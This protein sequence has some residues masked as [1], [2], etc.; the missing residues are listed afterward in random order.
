MRNK[1]LFLIACAFFMQLTSVFSIPVISGVTYAPASV[2]NYDK[3]E[4]SF[5]L[6][7]YTNPFDPAVVDAYCEFWSPTNVY[8]RVNAFY[9]TSYTEDSAWASCDTVLF[10]FSR[11]P[12]LTGTSNWRIRFTP[13]ELG[14]WKYKI[15]V[16]DAGGTATA[17]APPLKP[18]QFVCVTSSNPGFIVKAN[19]RFLKRTTGEFFFPVGMNLVEYNSCG[20]KTYG[21]YEYKY[22]LD[23]MDTNMNYMRVWIDNYGGA[24]LVGYDQA[25]GLVYYDQYD[26]ADAWRMDWIFDY[27]K[28]KNINIQ[29]CF[30]DH[31]PL[32]DDVVHGSYLWTQR[33]PYNIAN[34]GMLSTAHEFFTNLDAIKR[35]KKLLRYIVA[36]WGY[37]T[38]L[39]GWEL[40]NE[41]N[42]VA[43]ITT[44]SQPTPSQYNDIKVWHDTIY[45]Y[46]RNI[47]PHKH[48]ITTSWGGDIDNYDDNPYHQNNEALFD[49]VDYSQNHNY[50][51]LSENLQN[52]FFNTT[53]NAINLNQQP[54]MTG[55]WGMWD[56]PLWSTGDPNGFELHNAVWS[57]SFSTAMGSA[58]AW[59]WNYYIDQRNLYHVFKPVMLFMNSL[60]APSQSTTPFK[61]E[62]QNGMRVYG[63]TDPDNRVVCGWAQDNNFSFQSLY[64]INPLHPYLQTFDPPSKPGSSSVNNTILLPVPDDGRAYKV[65]WYD[66]QTGLIHSTTS[67]TSVIGTILIAM[68]PALRTSRFGDGVFKVYPDCNQNIWRDGPLTNSP[69]GNAAENVICNKTTGQVF[70]KTT[71]NTINSYWWN[72]ATQTWDL[73]NLNS[74]GNNVAG[75]L[76]I[77]PDGGTIYYRNTSN[78]INCIYWNA[79]ISNWSYSAMNSAATNVIGPITVGPN[80]Q[81]FYRDNANKL[82]SIVFNAGTS[83]WNYDG[84]SNASP[85]T[86]G[87]SIGVGYGVNGTDLEV[88]YKTTTGGINSLYYGSGAWHWSNVN[89]VASG[90]TSN[91]AVSPVRRFF[92]Q[93]AIIK[94]TKSIIIH[95]PVPG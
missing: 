33:N 18:R 31:H 60:S 16:T 57:S 20:T 54:V 29:L 5:N 12:L 43:K 32:V 51:N 73:S 41:V 27:A 70:Y 39:M 59:S 21:T 30:F 83:T 93:P 3:V 17:P 48:L 24:A 6:G 89:N 71:S 67:T 62:N 38:N 46:V 90:V 64:A 74:M 13:N 49:I 79:G 44:G 68:P 63:M 37:S 9:Y 10:P 87:N 40:W 15:T 91:I 65:D 56:V 53:T 50:K 4:I 66:S 36:R 58:A 25:T 42:Q 11:E 86:V 76:A 8:Y 1:N 45:T 80:N 82:R 14:T 22:Y 84:L 81:V 19:E 85:A 88:F 26:M 75:D 78:V 61:D 2:N 7:T 69:T 94:C 77:S 52:Y 92:I 28:S 34:G 23:Q 95:Q 55:E 47:D 72:S 35:T